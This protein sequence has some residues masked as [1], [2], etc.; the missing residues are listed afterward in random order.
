LRYTGVMDLIRR[1]AKRVAVDAAGYALLVLAVLTGWLPGPGGIP[2]AIAGLGLLSIHNKWAR[3]LRDYLLK[4]G[5]ELVKVLFP[6]N[7]I[8]QWLYDIVAVLLL[9][10]VTVL[11]FQHDPLW[12]ISAA[13]GLFFIAI[14][15][16]ALNRDRYMRFR[17]R[18]H[19]Q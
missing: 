6:P 19:K 7:P 5:G 8:I 11:A 9:L 10:L 13:V 4:H 15:L 2:L 1:N 14:F 12:K 3:R 16:A 17:Q 18:K